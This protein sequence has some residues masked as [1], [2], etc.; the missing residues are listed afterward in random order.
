[1]V[2]FSI[3]WQDRV[4]VLSPD[5]AETTAAVPATL[6]PA[7]LAHGVGPYRIEALIGRGRIAAVYLATNKRSGR[8]V[9]LK[10]L[11]PEWKRYPGA[12]QEFLGSGRAM[13]KIRHPNIVRVHEVGEDGDLRF[14][15]MQ[16]VRG[17]DLRAFLADAGELPPPRALEILAPAADALDLAHTRGVVHADLKP[18]NV[19][20]EGDTAHV[21]VTD[22]LAWANFPNRFV[23]T[24]EYASPEQ[25]MREPPTG[26]SD[27]YSFGCL[28]FECLTGGAPYA[29]T[30]DAD[31]IVAHLSEPP[32]RAGGLPTTVNDVLAKAMAKSP[33]DRYGSCGAVVAA[34]RTALDG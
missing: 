15:A 5:D 4:E 25:L 22:F 7:A 34:L 16:Y 11:P 23:G 20:V 31:V 3:R 19:L 33:K 21:Y 27:V 13:A 12:C 6:E 18:G 30:A 9:S 28:A 24:I 32:P 10:V 1:M 26:R 17:S 8:Q 29:R 2:S 14:V